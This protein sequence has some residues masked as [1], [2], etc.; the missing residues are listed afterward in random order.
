[1][2]HKNVSCSACH[3]Q[4][5]P[6]CIGCH[7]SF[8]KNDKEGYDLLD[9][10]EVIGQWIEHI[11]DFY[12]DKPA[13]GVRFEGAKRLIEPAVPGMIMTIDH[14]SFSE[15][16]KDKKSFHRLYAPN[17]PHTITKKTRDCNSCHANPTAIGYGEGKL[18][19]DTSQEY[20]TWKFTPVY[21]LNPNDKLPEDAW[22]PFLKPQKAKVFSTRTDFRPF[23]LKEQ[24]RI[25]LVGAC[26]QCHKEDSTII[27]QTLK[28]GLDPLFIKLSKNCILPKN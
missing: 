17:A 25:L 16:K 11:A 5:A 28:F 8:D 19:Y 23:T 15:D 3:T 27:Q 21:E 13:M 22:I 9:K 18:V 4:W 12:V 1:M 2:A 26:L 7:T 6:R 24:K 20:G 14:Q 10:K